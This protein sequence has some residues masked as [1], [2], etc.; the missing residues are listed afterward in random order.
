[1]DEQDRLGGVLQTSW[2]GR[3]HGHAEGAMIGASIRDR[4]ARMGGRRPEQDVVRVADLDRA[5][6]R[7]EEN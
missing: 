5:H 4:R 2:H 3:V 1:M 7:D 6:D